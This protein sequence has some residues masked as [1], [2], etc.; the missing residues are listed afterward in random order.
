ML[1]C[2]VAD[3][4]GSL[5]TGL[6]LPA[7]K[8]FEDKLPAGI[9]HFSDKDVSVSLVVVIDGCDNAFAADL[10]A[11]IRRMQTANGPVIYT[12]GLLYDIPYSDAR[13]TRHDLNLSRTRLEASHFSPIQ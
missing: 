7:F 1:Y 2:T 13:R 5:I 6:S 9:N 12:I 10:P 8:V 4:K 11:V 3:H